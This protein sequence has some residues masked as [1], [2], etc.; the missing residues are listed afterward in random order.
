MA[1]SLCR[2]L[3]F[4]NHALVAI[5]MVANMSFNA[6]RENEII[7]KFQKLHDCDIS[8]KKQQHLSK[9]PNH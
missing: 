1:L 7:A 5:F 9:V 6:D 8:T 2:L 4:V 3:I